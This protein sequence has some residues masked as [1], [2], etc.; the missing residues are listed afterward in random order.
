MKKVILYHLAIIIVLSGF[1]QQDNTH[2]NT[3]SI[4]INSQVEFYTYI[5][6]YGNEDNVSEPAV[7]FILTIYNN[8]TDP[9]PD[10]AV[11][12]RSNYVKLLVDDIISNPLSLYNGSEMIGP[13][14]ILSGE[15]DTYIWWFFIKDAYSEQ[16]VVQWQYLDLLSSRIKV[17]IYTESILILDE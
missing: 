11:T 4:T 6:P 5:G 13:H 3:D 17:N 1:S 14:E 7:K 2:I 15:S 12:N 8:G 10:L 16:F 9:I